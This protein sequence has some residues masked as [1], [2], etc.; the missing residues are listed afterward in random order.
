MTEPR[1]PTPDDVLAATRRVRPF[2]IETPL[3]RHDALDAA[4]GAQVWIKP[5]C[6]QI[7]GSFKIRGASNR[8]TQL[9][10][11]ERSRGVVAYSSGNHAQGVARA[12]R[13][14]DTPATII[15][16][17]DAP[18]VKVDGVRADGAT[19]VAYDRWTESREAIAAE[20]SAKTGAVIVPSYDDPHI[21]AGQGTTGAEIAQQA[22]QLGA[23]LDHL[24]CC[25][26]GGGLVSGI[27]LAMEALSPGTQVWGAEPEHHDDW[28]RSLEAGKICRNAA[29]APSSI[30]DAILTPEPGVITWAVGGPRL[31]GGFRVSDAEISAAM[32]FAFRHLKLVVEPGGAAALAALLSH[33][34]ESWTGQSVCIVLTGG[35]VD[36]ARFAQSLSASAP[37]PDPR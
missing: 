7:T 6:L 36:P 19:L 30:C 18:E 27:A 3:L 14:L 10:P 20:L 25:V 31:A 35:N 2:A 5:E 8:L 1:L 26:G 17:S 4:T 33:R 12:A 13:L 9:S 21:L 34:P 22:A 15:M 24:V 29:D 37:G 32:R 16:P 28:A 23:P 11:E